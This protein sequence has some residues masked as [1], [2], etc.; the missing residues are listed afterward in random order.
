VSPRSNGSPWVAS[1]TG[2]PTIGRPK[3][4]VLHSTNDAKA[5]PG[6]LLPE[7]AS[8]LN[9]LGAMLSDLERWKEALQASSAAV[10]I[11]RTLAQALPDAFLPDVAKSLNNLGAML[12]AYPGRR[13]GQIS[14]A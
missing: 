13:C 9:D 14:W 2:R 12:R 4:G 7:L 3:E 10:D 11:R 8:S 6:T 1:L 5:R